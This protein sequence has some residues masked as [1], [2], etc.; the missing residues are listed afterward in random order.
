MRCEQFDQRWQQLMDERRPWDSDPHLVAHT[1]RCQHCAELAAGG[2]QLLLGL[3]I[4][5]PDGLSADFAERVVAA[6]T[7]PAA[8]AH[9]S[10]QALV[11]C[12]AVIA[13]G[14]LLMLTIVPAPAPPRQA[15]SP[16]ASADGGAPMELVADAA[17]DVRDLVSGL[18]E[19]FP[20]DE[21]ARV[22]QRLDSSVARPITKSFGTAFTA[23]YRTLPVPGP[24][25]KSAA[26]TPADRHD[27]A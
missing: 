2:E 25:D 27:L 5:P 6:A 12:V 21:A 10:W 16:P 11:S 23:I 14:L 8:D 7:V 13:A 22:I 15:D 26:R 24:R 1:L 20:H 19:R 17:P 9:H 3:D 18:A 4:D